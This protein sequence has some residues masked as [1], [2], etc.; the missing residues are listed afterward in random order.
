MRRTNIDTMPCTLR[1][2]AWDV[3]ILTPCLAHFAP[4]LYPQLPCTAYSNMDIGLRVQTSSYVIHAVKQLKCV[5]TWYLTNYFGDI[6]CWKLCRFGPSCLFSVADVHYLFFLLWSLPVRF[7]LLLPLLPSASRLLL[8]LSSPSTPPPHSP[9]LLLRLLL[10]LLLL[11]VVL[12]VLLF[13]FLLLFLFSSPPPPPLPSP[14]TPFLFLLPLLPFYSAFSSSSLS[15]F[16]FFFFSFS[17]SSLTTF[18]T[19]SLLDLR[20][21]QCLCKK[22]QTATFPWICKSMGLN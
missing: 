13:L 5:T 19:C 1:T 9:R 20:L 10:L 12:L 8:L 16:F 15:F 6:C 4:K 7:L 11:L 3:P 18:C 2:K 21:L 14:P 17:S 22:R